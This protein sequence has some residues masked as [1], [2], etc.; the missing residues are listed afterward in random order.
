[1]FKIKVDK[2]EG[3]IKVTSTSF[4]N[5]SNNSFTFKFTNFLILYY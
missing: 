2:K 1:L 5:K 4:Y 3:E